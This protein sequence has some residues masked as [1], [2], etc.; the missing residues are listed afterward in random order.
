[1]KV[2]TSF[3]SEYL[4]KQP[5]QRNYYQ[6]IKAAPGVNADY[7]SS[8]GSAMLAYGGTS[9]SQNAFTLDG[10]NVADAGAGQHWILPSIQWMEEIQVA[11][12]GAAAEYGGY[13]GAIINGVTKSGGNK[14]E[15][16]V[17]I[18][19]QPTDWVADNTPD[20]VDEEFKFEDYSVSLGGP[21]VQD[22]LWYFLSGEYWHQVT[23]PYGAV[24]TS[25]REIPRLLG[26]LTFQANE[27]NRLSLMT[28]WDS[29]TNER[30]GISESTLPEASS[31]QEAPGTS[32]SI[33][34]ESLINDSNFTNVRLTGYDGRDDYLPYNG[35]ELPGRIDED[36]GIAWT[37]Q[38][39]Q[40]L[41]HRRIVTLDASWSLFAD[42]LFGDDDS[43]TFKFGAAYEDASSSDRWLRNGGF[44]YY[45][46]SSLCESFD[47][48]LANPSCGPYYVERG[49]GEYN[50]HPEFTGLAL[51]AQDSLRLDRVT[52]NAGLRYGSY[53]GGWQSGHGDASVYDASFVD[54]RVG[55][56]WDVKG[57][58][59]TAL[60]VHW[61]RY[62]DK[63][64]TYLYDREASGEAVVPD[65]DCYWD[66][67]T[68]GY[69]DCDE[70]TVIAARMGEVDHPYVDETLVSFE[71]Q[72]GA[73]ML[74]GIDLLDRRFNSIMAM[75]NANQD[76]E[77]LT[78]SNPITGGDLPIWNLLSEADFVLT[79]DN[80]AYR[81]FQSAT[82]RLDKRYSDGWSL[83]SS[84]VWT[85]LEG[86]ILKN[87][88][89]AN[90]FRDRNGLYNADGR[91]DLAFSEWEFK[92]SGTVDLPWG[93]QFGGQY[94]F[95][96]GWYWTPYGRVSG[97]DYNSSIGRDINLVERGSE[98]LDDR[99]LVDL[100]LAWGTQLGDT[101]RLTASLEVF[102]A[103]NEDTVVDVYNRWGSYRISRD[104]WTPR[105]DF[106]TPYQIERP[107]EIRAGL[108]F[109]F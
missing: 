83:R 61:G 66:D 17:E 49:W 54:P 33:G 64:Y 6:I 47:A 101:A 74:I 94:T 59:R 68:G 48:Y 21:V 25:D 95:L 58:A 109:E 73:N 63:M 108:R 92:L 13:T 50:A 1:N 85:D 15:G 97:L 5:V 87:N 18:F 93:F 105:D 67:E 106:G 9:E 8:S 91:M 51:Y 69:T 99:S 81:D 88:G 40:E 16:G 27:A 20:S 102:N 62:H 75:V 2:A 10:V 84:L 65:L 80:G 76:Y 29:V 35:T 14:V 55:L 104:T 98:Q 31:K 41:N 89:Y 26:K 30:R 70:P 23:T 107:R 11:G 46:D 22:K 100:R 37:N 79:T 96:S 38:A 3:T 57:D 42:G 4:E 77:L 71:Q 28:E 43:H 45:D 60:K 36:S 44:T 34:W 7:T 19:Y 24:D 78:G 103:F 32:V 90:E 52:I 82:V 53:D 12:L 86:N 72:V 56:V 39:I